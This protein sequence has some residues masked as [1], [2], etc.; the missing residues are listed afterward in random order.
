MLMHLEI[1]S[2]LLCA[3]YIPRYVFFLSVCVCAKGI[4]DGIYF[5]I[6]QPE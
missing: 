4:D 6:M 2:W 3:A 1:M 5:M